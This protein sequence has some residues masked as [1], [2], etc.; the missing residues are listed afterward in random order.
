ML[1]VNADE[2]SLMKRFH[3]PGDEKRMLVI[4]HPEQYQGWLEGA[5]VNSEE[6][7]RPYPAEQLVAVPDPLAPRTKTKDVKLDAPTGTGWQLF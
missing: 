1:T 2:H 4:L 7:Y 6:V 3:K 5:L